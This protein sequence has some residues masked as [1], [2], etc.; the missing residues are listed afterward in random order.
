MT[1]MQLCRGCN[2]CPRVKGSLYCGPC[3][4]DMAEMVEA[5]RAH[6]HAPEGNLC[7]CPDCTMAA[8]RQFRQR[9]AQVA[10]ARAL[11]RLAE[12]PLLWKPEDPDPNRPGPRAA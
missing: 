6:L 10:K 4:Q 1:V 9:E 7:W 2:R 8:H 3:S 12:Q 5:S 11:A